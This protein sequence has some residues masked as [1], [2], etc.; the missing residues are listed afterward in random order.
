MKR[1]TPLDYK[2]R[3]KPVWC[4]G[5]GDYGVLAALFN[6]FSQKG[7]D[8]KDVAIV[9]GIGCSGR[10]PDFIKAYGFHGAHGR[11]LPVAIGVKVANPSLHVFV[12]GGDGDGL[13]I[14]AGHFPHAARKNI[15]MTYI[16]MDNSLFGMTK[17]QFSPTS[18]CKFE[19]G[20]SPYGTL[21][22]PMDPIALSLIYGST[23]VARGYSGPS[24]IDALINIIR[25]AMEHKGFSF[26][27][28]LSPCI[29]YNKVVT[30]Q[31]LNAQVVDIDETHRIDD[32]NGALALALHEEKLSVGLFYKITKPTFNERLVVMNEKCGKRGLDIERL[33]AKFT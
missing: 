29:T 3:N 8:T 13:S 27:H 16:L 30:F 33:Y 2:G 18:P 1:H 21:E 22:E 20:S 10:L 24:K 15:D 26:I 14:G 4:A 7:I 32:R 28:A 19:S 25:E 6:A 17:G 23:F 5:C 31:S 12:V 11:A 9:S